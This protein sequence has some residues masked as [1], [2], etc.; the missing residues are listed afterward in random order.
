MVP[1]LAQLEAD[2]V[3]DKA[4]TSQHMG[5]GELVVLTLRRPREVLHLLKW[6]KL[7]GFSLYEALKGDHDPGMRDP[8]TV[9]G[10]VGPTGATGSRAGVVPI[11]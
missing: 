7:H 2:H 5:D 1:T 11:P 6:Q 3:E 10:G 9:G 4:T 8:G